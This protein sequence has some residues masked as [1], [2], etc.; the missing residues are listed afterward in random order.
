MLDVNAYVL[1]HGRLPRLGDDPAPW[2]YRGWLLW[3]VQ[4]IDPHGRWD[5]YLRTLQA[6]KLLDEPIPTIKFHEEGGDRSV[7]SD[8]G[9][10][11]EVVGYDM[12]G[13]SDFRALIDWL[14]WGLATSKEEPRIHSGEAGQEKLYRLVNVGPMLT[15]PS[16]YLGQ[17]ISEGKSGRWNP[18]AFFPTPHC[19]CECMVKMQM[20]DESK[21]GDTRLKSVCDPCVG[22]GRML[23]HAS[24]FS[25][26]LYGNDI[27]PLV[28][29][30]C[31]INGA[32]YAPWLAF[33]F[34]GS[35]VPAVKA[36]RLAVEPL[37]PALAPAALAAPK[38]KRREA[39]MPLFEG[40]EP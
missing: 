37:V 34:P 1:E 30:C 23:L 31:K 40:Q 24:N 20:H 18:T 32:L 6:G 8:I 16:D 11:S 4:M 29:A 17:F 2:K 27:D 38:S 21:E 10:W 9:K 26:N 5:Y 3:Y 35:I 7:L 22:T 25:L 12:G 15:K 19:V 13:W 33:P 28:V 14:S 39:P 36:D